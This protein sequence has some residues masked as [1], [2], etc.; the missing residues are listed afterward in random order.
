MKSIVLQAHSGMIVYAE[1]IADIETKYGDKVKII[2]SSVSAGLGL[3]WN[4]ETFVG[5][6]DTVTNYHRRLTEIFLCIQDKFEILEA[7]KAWLMSKV[8][9][10]LWPQLSATVFQC[11]S[12]DSWNQNIGGIGNDS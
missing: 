8:F 2:G 3:E 5:K 11:W 4:L 10:S 7:R 1:P 12:T 9:H 6:E